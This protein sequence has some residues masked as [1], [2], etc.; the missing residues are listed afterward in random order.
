MG[1]A[2]AGGAGRG[3]AGGTAGGGGPLHRPFH[4][5]ACIVSGSRPVR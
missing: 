5:L 3:G 4:S 1:A 2:G